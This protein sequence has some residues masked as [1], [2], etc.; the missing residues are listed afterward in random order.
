[1][2]KIAVLMLLD[3]RLQAYANINA[4]SMC[5]WGMGIFVAVLCRR[6]LLERLH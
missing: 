2:E 4:E 5:P 6:S 1:M 3:I